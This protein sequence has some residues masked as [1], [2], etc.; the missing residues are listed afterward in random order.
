MK[1]IY[2]TI[3]LLTIFSIAMGF[4]E[5]ALV[6]YLR[7]IYYPTGFCFPLVPL[8]PLILKTE[9]LREAA[10]LIML[11]SIATIAGKGFIQKFVF[12]LFCFAIWDIF[13]YI[14][15]KLL[16]DWPSSLLTMDILF[17]I[18]VPWIGPVLAPC[19]LSLTMILVMILVIYFQQ[20]NNKVLFSRLDWV[21]MILASFIIIISFTIDYLSAILNSGS[22]QTTELIMYTL[23]NY[24]PGNFNWFIFGVGWAILIV[25]FILVFFRNHKV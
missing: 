5:S 6:V 7:T 9:L 3:A 18:P 13:Y 16:I 23:E 21:L 8:D 22:S 4:M 15:L 19:L 24:I 12:F 17:L 11:I 14:F 10:T 1:P 2:K 20:S 25:D